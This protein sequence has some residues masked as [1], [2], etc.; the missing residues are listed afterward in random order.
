MSGKRRSRL[1]RVYLTIMRGAYYVLS[2]YNKADAIKRAKQHW[3]ANQL[4]KGRRYRLTVD[5]VEWLAR[6]GLRTLHVKH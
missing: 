4:H 5:K 3:R 6:S 2:A 1:Y